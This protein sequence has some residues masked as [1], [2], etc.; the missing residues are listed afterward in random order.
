MLFNN[1]ATPCQDLVLLLWIGRIA[2]F[3]LSYYNE[4]AWASSLSSEYHSCDQ[5][6]LKMFRRVKRTCCPDSRHVSN[7]DIHTGVDSVNSYL[8]TVFKCS[9]DVFTHE[10]SLLCASSPA[11]IHSVL[12]AGMML[13]KSI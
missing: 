4:Q 1:Q 12:Q 8:Y 6:D 7:V 10:I 3:P 11:I 13:K 2:Q 9:D 5:S